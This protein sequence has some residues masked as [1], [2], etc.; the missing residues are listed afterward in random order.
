MMVAALGASPATFAQD[1]AIEAD[2]IS[3]D[4]VSVDSL[5][6]TEPTADIDTI[7]ATTQKLN[8]KQKVLNYAE[9]K[10]WNSLDRIAEKGRFARFCVDTYRW[11]DR[12]FN[13]YDTAY[14]VGVGYN[15]KVMLKGDNWFDR[16][17]FNM[18]SDPNGDYPLEWEGDLSSMLGF[19]V[20]FMAVSVGYSFDITRMHNDQPISRKVLDFDFC[21][22]R[23]TASLRYI[24]NKDS[25]E[26]MEYLSSIYPGVEVNGVENK[27]WDIT[28]YYFFNN[29]KYSQAA[30]YN[31]SK[32]QKRSAGS[33]IAG[34]AITLNN[35][36]ANLTDPE[37][38]LPELAELHNLNLTSNCYNILLGY[39]YNWVPV[40]N[41]V[42]NVTAYP[43]IG[44]RYGHQISGNGVDVSRTSFSFNIR[45]RSAITYNINRRW[46]VSAHAMYYRELYHRP[47]YTFRSSLGKFGFLA[48]FRF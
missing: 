36:R 29:F 31:Y 48:G 35:A 39:G 5:Q 9:R 32:I 25:V 16:Y 13:T 21:S 24:K 27:I 34:L 17:K 23:V 43:T 44:W 28:A 11:G 14:V 10:G 19:T 38:Y 41:L 47:G 26:D 37:G 7:A 3:T 30:A 22:S 4:I 40:R 42:I 2:S 1:S 12:L 18:E 33:P 46:F 8:L 15:W 45:L 20:A 6:H